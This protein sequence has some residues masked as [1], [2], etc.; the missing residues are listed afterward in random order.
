MIPVF[1]NLDTIAA[2]SRELTDSLIKKNEQLILSTTYWTTQLSDELLQMRQTGL[3]NC[4][5][6]QMSRNRRWHFRWQ[7][8]WHFNGSQDSSNVVLLPIPHLQN[9]MKNSKR[10][11]RAM[12]MEQLSDEMTRRYKSLQQTLRHF[13]KLLIISLQ[14]QISWDRMALTYRMFFLSVAE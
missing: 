12:V 10:S 4:K 1:A 5:V 6:L 14:N 3:K 8:L 11:Q 7:R 9:I 13:L 2:H